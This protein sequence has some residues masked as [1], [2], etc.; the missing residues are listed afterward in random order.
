MEKRFFIPLVIV[1]VSGLVTFVGA[2]PQDD[3][4]APKAGKDLCLACHGSFDDIAAATTNF[5]L[6]NGATISPHHYIPYGDERIIP[7]C[8]SCHEPHPIPLES[9][10]QAKRPDNIEWCYTTCHHN[11]LLQSC[12]NC[13]E[14]DEFI[15]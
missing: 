6:S 13:H 4:P 12:N 5:V 7:E 15:E 11:Y 10:E 14:F 9:K 8:V 1:L 3:S 2:I